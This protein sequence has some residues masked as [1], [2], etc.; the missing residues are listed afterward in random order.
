LVW[1]LP[2]VDL[3]IIFK[4]GEGT[5]LARAEKESWRA[6]KPGEPADARCVGPTR[7]ERFGARCG[8]RSVESGACVGAMIGPD[9]LGVIV[10]PVRRVGSSASVAVYGVPVAVRPIVT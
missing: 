9:S 8:A 3:R 10:E 7:E 5:C 6:R 1:Y 2:A 4:K